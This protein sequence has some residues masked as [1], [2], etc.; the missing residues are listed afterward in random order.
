MDIK[1]ES[2]LMK[3]VK[4]DFK[5]YNVIY[6]DNVKNID[7]NK[8][9]FKSVFRKLF[10]VESNFDKMLLNDKLNLNESKDGIDLIIINS[11]V[12]EESGEEILRAYLEDEAQIVE[13]M[14]L[15]DRTKQVSDILSLLDLGISTFVDKD[16]DKAQFLTSMKTLSNHIKYNKENETKEKKK[17]DK[18]PRELVFSILESSIPTYNMLKNFLTKN[19]VEGRNISNNRNADEFIKEIQKNK[20]KIDIVIIGKYE[21]NTSIYDIVKNIFNANK[22]IYVIVISETSDKQIIE[23]LLKY[24]VRDVFLKPFEENIISKK[25]QAATG[26]RSVKS[27][28]L[29]KYLYNIAEIVGDYKTFSFNKKLN[30]GD[31]DLLKSF[32]SYL[33][34]GKL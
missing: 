16:Y 5:D 34:D 15:V 25:I 8:L 26:V 31:D 20:A 29:N 9:F 10:I 6:I 4:Q 7:K 33:K 30:I 23:E 1:E 22:E 28:G 24:G 18:L 13:V 2:Q 21:D 12:N 32:I 19:R 3:E 14:M 17:K 27:L 11:T